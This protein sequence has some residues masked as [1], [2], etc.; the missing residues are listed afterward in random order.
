MM[1]MTS[2]SG[3]RGLWG[4]RVSIPERG[5]KESAIAEFRSTVGNIG[6]SRDEVK[7]IL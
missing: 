7:K 1:K 5:L 3:M 6:E 4:G 2:A